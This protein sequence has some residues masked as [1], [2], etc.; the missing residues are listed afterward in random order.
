MGLLMGTLNST[1]VGVDLLWVQFEWPLGLLVLSV[2]FGRLMNVEQS[3]GG[4]PD[5]SGVYA[6]LLPWTFFANSISSSSESIVAASTLITR[7]YFPRIIIPLTSVCTALVDFA[8]AS[9]I[10]LILM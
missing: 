10:L 7:V 8:V 5:P 6:G 2:L 9:I 1:R 4:G 3:T